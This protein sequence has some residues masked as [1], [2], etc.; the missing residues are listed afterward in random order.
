MQLMS[1]KHV[2][3]NK[4]RTLK[5]FNVLSEFFL[6]NTNDVSKFVTPRKYAIFC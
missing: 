5:I 2:Y 4:I 3:S 6:E 1:E